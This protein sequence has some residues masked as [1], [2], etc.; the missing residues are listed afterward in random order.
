M[1]RALL[2]LAL[3]LAAAA[4]GTVPAACPEL[5]DTWNRFSHDANAYVRGLAINVKDARA[6]ARL[7]REWAAVTRCA[8]W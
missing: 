4:G 3:T 7:D 8:C 1:R 2:L 6:H 5:L